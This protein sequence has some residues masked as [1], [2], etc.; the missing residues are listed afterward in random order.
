MVDIRIYRAGFVLA[1][2]SFVV[3]MFSLQERPAPL[4][5]TLAPDAFDELG[6]TGLMED[7]VAHNPDRRPGSAGD[8]K[9]ASSVQSRLQGLGFETSRDDFSAQVDG[10]E[11]GL[12]NVIR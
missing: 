2:L 4:T 1:L 7:I 8:R 10:N 11:T 12:T 9:L 6:A 3:V 5:S